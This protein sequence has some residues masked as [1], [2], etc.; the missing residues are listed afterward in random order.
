VTARCGRSSTLGRVQLPPPPFNI[1]SFTQTLYSPST[2]SQLQTLRRAAVFL[3]N[4]VQLSTLGMHRPKAAVA[5][6]C[7]PAKPVVRLYGG[8]PQSADS[9]RKPFRC[10][11]SATSTRISEKPARK[12]RKVD[13]SGA[14]GDDGESDKPYS[15][16]DRLALATRD[17]NRFPVF[18][19]K[20]R[21]TL[22][23]Q[24]FSIPLLNKDTGAYNSN[25]P[26]PLLGMRQGTVFVARPLHDPSGEFGIV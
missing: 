20:D 1:T 22:F 3:L 21:D 19:A 14:G 17:A 10:P 12:R 24:R 13:Y 8:T 9:L 26:A 16:E 18:K 2:L 23:K 6:E 25:R 5:G 15:N 4:I 11:G 7:I